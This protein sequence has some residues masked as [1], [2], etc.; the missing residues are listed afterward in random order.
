[1]E[2]KEIDPREFTWEMIENFLGEEKICLILN[3][4]TDFGDGPIIFTGQKVDGEQ[5]MVISLYQEVYNAKA[6]KFLKKTLPT[7]IVQDYRWNQKSYHGV[8]YGE[9][10]YFGKSKVI[11]RVEK[12]QMTD[13][14]IV[15]QG[16]T[17]KEE[18]ELV[19]YQNGTYLCPRPSLK[20]RDNI[21]NVIKE[22]EALRGYWTVF[23]RKNNKNQRLIIEVGLD[24]RNN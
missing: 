22:V 14:E 10:K 11:E 1:L 23:L 17:E 13:G 5:G 19:I 20:L 12:I 21:P 18:R 2:K 6:R 9:M 24:N 4:I 16:T 7:I 3:S 8:T 15:F